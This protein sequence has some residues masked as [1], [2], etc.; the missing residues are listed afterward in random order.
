VPLSLAYWD[1]NPPQAEDDL[2]ENDLEA[3]YVNFLKAISIVV[4]VV[5]QHRGMKA[6]EARK[7]VEADEYWIVRKVRPSRLPSLC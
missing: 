3:A 2:R 1:S 7:T 6:I 5:P 4:E